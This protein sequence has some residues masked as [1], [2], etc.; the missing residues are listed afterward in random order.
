MNDRKRVRQDFELFLRQLG[1]DAQG[2]TEHLRL[3][4]VRGKPRDSRDC[5]IARYLSLV[6]SG[7]ARVRSVSVRRGDVRVLL[8]R[9][10]WLPIRIPLSP[11]LRD[12]ILL[13]DASLLPDLVDQRDCDSESEAEHGATTFA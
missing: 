6:T 1:Q 11:A 5:A 13:F 7:D 12:F 2:V 8:S 9:P 10:V 4:G 3:Q